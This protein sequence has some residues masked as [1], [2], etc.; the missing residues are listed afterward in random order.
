MADK[1]DL[2]HELDVCRQV[3]A[4]ILKECEAAD[5]PASEL[6]ERLSPIF[7]T[8]SQ[9]HKLVYALVKVEKMRS[10]QLGKSDVLALAM[11]VADIAAK[12]VPKAKLKEFGAEVETLLANN[13][14]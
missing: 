4:N 3:L 11:Q 12:F 14:Q 7:R 9:I 6:I 8:T 10:Q 1:L 5:N 13:D 2:S